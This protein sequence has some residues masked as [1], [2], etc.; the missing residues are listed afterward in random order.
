MDGSDED[1]T[2]GF[3]REPEALAAARDLL[4]RARSVLVLTGAGVSADS[5]VP[6]F[7]GEDGLWEGSRPE[8]LAT[9]EAFRRDPRRVWA[10]YGMRREAVSACEP[11]A[12]HVALARWSAGG[13]PAVRIATQNVDGLHGRALARVTTGDADGGLPDGAGGAPASPGAVPPPPHPLELHGSLF[14]TRCTGCGRRRAASGP[15]DASSEGTLP[16]CGACGALLRPDVVW[17]GEALD[18]EMMEAAGRAAVSA[19]ACLV[20]GT[21]A[22]VQPAASLATVA[23]RSGAA[24]VEVNPERTPLTP[25]ADVHLAGR[26]ARLVPELLDPA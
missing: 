22:V 2:E 21:S 5:G 13:A 1:R 26:A 17:F 14:R 19:D 6:T 16:R 11:N 3:G 8:E 15:V 25:H 10:W 18:A 24:L 9:P 4:G 12:A 20:V 23:A 7:R